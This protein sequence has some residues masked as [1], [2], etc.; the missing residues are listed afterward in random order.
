[1]TVCPSCSSTNIIK[2]GKNRNK[3][4][5][6]QRYKCKSCQKTFT[7]KPIKNKPYP[8]N[9]ILNA[10]SY[11]NQGYSLKISAETI[12]KQYK[13][14]LSP[15]TI[16]NW[17]KELKDLTTFQRLRKKALKY[18]KPKDMIIKRTFHHNQQP[19]LYQYHNS[20]IHFLKKYPRLKSY[21]QEVKDNCPNHLFNN[22]ERCHST[23]NR[24]N[25][26]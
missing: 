26:A 8:I 6:I 22:N 9:I 19:Y 7:L 17:L 20:K 13:L 16:K 18:N 15:Q 2:K 24:L 25:G 5:I 4:E 3:L 23:L 12:K 1:M 14:N 11:Y 10:V 21:L